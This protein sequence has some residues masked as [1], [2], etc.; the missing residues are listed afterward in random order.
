MAFY[1]QL[2]NMQIFPED[3]LNVVMEYWEF[4]TKYWIRKNSLFYY[5]NIIESFTP[6]SD[7]SMH[8]LQIALAH[9]SNQNYEEASKWLNVSENSGSQQISNRIR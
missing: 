5:K 2:A 7:N 8:S 9:I 6:S 1:Y 4:S 3:R